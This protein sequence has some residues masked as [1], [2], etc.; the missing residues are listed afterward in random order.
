MKK[1]IKIL[2]NNSKNGFTLIEML[3]TIGIIAIML[4]VSI[5]GFNNYKAI[6]NIKNIANRIQSTIYESRSLALS[7]PIEKKENTEYFGIVIKKNP[8]NIVE[9]QKFEAGDFENIN[10]IDTYLLPQGY[11]LDNELEIFFSIS[12]A[13]KIEQIIPDENIVVLELKKIDNE[14]LKKYIIINK[15]TSQVIINDNLE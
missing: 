5:P 9:V 7:P 2:K 11:D 15:I 13:G 1:K 10:I 8:N 6:N 3:V 12:K 4:V 14:K